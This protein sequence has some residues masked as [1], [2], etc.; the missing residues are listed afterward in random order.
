L[1]LK[2]FVVYFLN[3]WRHSEFAFLVRRLRL[4]HFFIF[5]GNMKTL[6][7]GSRSITEFDLSPYVPNNTSVIISGGASGV[8]T[9]AERYADEQK[10]SKYII[11]PRYELYRRNA[12]LVRNREM[13]EMADFVLVIWDGA[14]RG[15]KSSIDYA[16]KTGKQVLVITD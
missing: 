9:L 12:P 8:D 3:V 1:G 16:K 4:A 2:W 13:I 15:T 7:I 5:G 11:R 10:L 6:I 14:S